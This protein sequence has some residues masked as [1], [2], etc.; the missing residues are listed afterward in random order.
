VQAETSGH[1]R[2]SFPAWSIVTYAFAATPSRPALKLFWYDGGKQPRKE[3]FEGV[4]GH[5]GGCLVIGEKGK[6]LFTGGGREG[7]R[8]SKDL[9]QPE[10]TFP[11]S[12]GHFEEFVRAIRG[13]E[14][15]LSNFPE[16]AGPLTETVLA[17][18]LAVWVANS[19]GTGPRLEWDAVHQRVT[20]HDGLE[21]LV[22]REYR[23]GYEL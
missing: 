10:V 6:M 12:P 9:A 2:D 16:Y 8:L 21:R 1:N 14:P 17:G 11:E 19:P 13:G 7:F 15:A 3:L 22:Q 18:N 4:D 5:G 23:K 20:N